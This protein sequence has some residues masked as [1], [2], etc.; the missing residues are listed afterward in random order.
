M[1]S[2]SAVD[3]NRPLVDLRHYVRW[4]DNVLPVELCDGL[5]AGFEQMRDAQVVNGVGVRKGLD[6][7]KW[8]ELNLSKFA[9]PA[10]KGY[11]ISLIDQYLERYNAEIGVSLPV[12]PTHLSSDLIIKRYAADK[13]EQFEPHFDSIYDRCDRYMV[14]LWYLNDVE[15]GGETR[16]MDLDMGVQARKGRLLMFPPYWMYQH[17]GMP[18]ISNAKYIVSTYLLFEKNPRVDPG[19]LSP[20]Q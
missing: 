18:P 3:A 14:F 15:E 12:P 16:F 7:S 4:Y 10:M 20:T 11:F 1:K 6:G 8:T 2:E 9:D 5:V 13:V 17:A 19:N